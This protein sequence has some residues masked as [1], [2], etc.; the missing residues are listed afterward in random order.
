MD[1]AGDIG[2]VAFNANGFELYSRVG[3]KRFGLIGGY[4][5]EAPKI[6]NPLL[7]PDFKVRYFILGAE[8]FLIKNG[9]IYS[10]SRIDNG[11][12]TATGQDGYNVFTIGFRYDF[13]F[14]L[15]HQP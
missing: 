9:K 2:T 14:R 5:Y 12:V 1:S 8:Y 7:N 6:R 10:E 11:S 4:T 3:I 15:S 13:S